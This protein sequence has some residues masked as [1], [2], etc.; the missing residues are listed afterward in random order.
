M[1]NSKLQHLSSCIA[2]LTLSL[3]TLGVFQ[4]RASETPAAAITQIPV[5]E[6]A[7]VK[8]IPSDLPD[9]EIVE[10]NFKEYCG[11]PQNIIV[12]RVDLKNDNYQLK[13]SSSKDTL[14]KT[15]QQASDNGGVL[16]VNGGFF[17]YKPVSGIGVLKADNELI[18]GLGANSLRECGVIAVDHDGEISF[19]SE[20]N[21]PHEEENYR[22]MILSYP[23][24]LENGEKP[25]SL[26][27]AG[28]DMYKFKNPRT[29]I[30]MT[31]DKVLYF[32]V[33]DGRHPG[34]AGGLTSIEMADF[35]LKLNCV[36]ALGM[37][38]GGSCT[39]WEK[40]SGVLNNPCDNKTFD[41]EGER[42]VHNVVYLKP[43]V[44]VSAQEGAE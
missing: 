8:V 2:I 39:I 13:V 30:G 32:V 21:R 11:A 25:Q 37:D 40:N 12:A 7:Q 41:H 42:K 18:N 29:T 34:Q 36:S 22:E 43:A 20:A 16:A 15:S 35:M 38:G 33:V 27:N 4:L 10:M 23:L 5:I 28:R 1:F 24:L 6:G 3:L 9:C 31:A 14:V 44:T 19:H 17:N 26:L